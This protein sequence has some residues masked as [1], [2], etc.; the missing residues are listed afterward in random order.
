MVLGAAD[1]RF[2]LN[3]SNANSVILAGSTL[4]SHGGSL[5]NLGTVQATTGATVTATSFTNSG[6]DA[7]FIVSTVN[8]GNG[9]LTLSGAFD[10]EGT[11]QSAGGLTVAAS[12]QTLDNSGV[13]YASGT[14]GSLSL[15]GQPAQQHQHRHHPGQWQRRHRHHARQR[16][17]PGQRRHGL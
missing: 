16:Q 5:T 12:G 6:S 14:S 8:G 17:R 7:A 3:N 2:N 4:T 9:T 13:I 15:S 10:N 11:L 1:H